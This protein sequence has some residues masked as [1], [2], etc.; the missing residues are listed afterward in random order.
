M[1]FVSAYAFVC[2]HVLTEADGVPSAIRIA[3]VFFL[4]YDPSDATK[5]RLP[6]VGVNLFVHIR[7]TEDDN[8]PH[9]MTFTLK[10][11]DGEAKTETITENKIAESKYANTD[12]TL[13]AIGRIGV[14][15]KQ[16]GKHE[17]VIHLDSKPVASA[18]FTLIQNQ[19]LY[20]AHPPKSPVVDHPR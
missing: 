4:P 16:L 8:D 12:K 6:A 1:A 2:Q 13:T 15:A 18:V 11:P 20:A 9:S 7:M 5:P 3:E 17:F 14:E 10:R 19:S